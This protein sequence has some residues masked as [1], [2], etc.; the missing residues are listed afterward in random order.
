[1]RHF[2]LPELKRYWL[3]TAV[4]ILAGTAFAVTVFP[5]Q[6]GAGI[7]ARFS[8]R[9]ADCPWL[10]GGVVDSCTV[11]RRLGKAAGDTFPRGGCRA[12]G[13][14]SVDDSFVVLPGCAFPLGRDK[15]GVGRVLCPSGAVAAVWLADRALSPL[16]RDLDRD[17][18]RH[19][20]VVLWSTCAHVNRCCC[21]QSD[22]LYRRYLAICGRLDNV[23]YAREHKLHDRVSGR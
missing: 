23:H 18:S 8:F 10:H 21:G 11:R 17:C 15:Q 3:V 12:A 16:L 19:V 9:L 4:I 6:V 13:S 1:M 22:R 2:A 14:C 20:R 7:P 5:R